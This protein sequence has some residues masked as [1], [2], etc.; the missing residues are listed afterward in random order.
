MTFDLV[1]LPGDRL[2]FG[3]EFL[4]ERQVFTSEQ[5]AA[6][7][8]TYLKSTTEKAIKK[9]VKDCVISVGYF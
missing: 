7:M 6:M 1:E 4:G 2:G 5:V 9:P 8:L 3:V